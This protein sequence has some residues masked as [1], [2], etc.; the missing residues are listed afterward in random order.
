MYEN[1][2]RKTAKSERIY[3]AGP[4][5]APTDDMMQANVQRGLNACIVILKLG[6]AP[7]C[8][9]LSYYLGV[10]ASELGTEITWDENIQWDDE[11]LK[12]SDSLY[13]IAPSPGADIELER[14]WNRGLKIYRSLSE[15][16]AVKA[17]EQ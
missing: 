12:Q 5:T 6:H 2:A 3:I 17:Q 4:I 15:I 11:W 14:A 8:P 9:H 1:I 10:S 13:Y 16:P 7:F